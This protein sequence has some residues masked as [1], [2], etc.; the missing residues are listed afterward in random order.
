MG[1][2]HDCDHEICILSKEDMGKTT[3]SV[4]NAQLNLALLNNG[5]HSGTR[6]IMS[7]FH[8]EE[9]IAKT[10]EAFGNALTDVR[11]EGLI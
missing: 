11:A 2:D 7:A 3:N 1:T 8:T 6:F 9:D 5:V 10:A 4:R